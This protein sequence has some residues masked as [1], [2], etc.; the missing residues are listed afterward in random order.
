MLAAR[1]VNDRKPLSEHQTSPKDQICF[2]VLTIMK[3]KRNIENRKF[4]IVKLKTS[5]LLGVSK[6]GRLKIV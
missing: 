4:E 1:V 3:G 6:Y 5:I 2:I